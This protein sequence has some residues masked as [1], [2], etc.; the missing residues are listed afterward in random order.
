[1]SCSVIIKKIIFTAYLWAESPQK[2][3]HP[4]TKPS[5]MDMQVVFESKG[6]V[7]E[8]CGGGEVEVG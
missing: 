1:M 8:C 4:N 5:I 7:V 2:K 6:S 3:L